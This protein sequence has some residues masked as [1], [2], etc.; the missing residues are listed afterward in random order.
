MIAFVN[1]A[2]S[3]AEFLPLP[4]VA[5]HLIHRPA[6]GRSDL[7]EVT[8]TINIATQNPYILLAWRI[9]GFWLLWLIQTIFIFPLD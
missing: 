3:S 7:L 6:R 2:I 9:V 1:E 5:S 4:S 8:A